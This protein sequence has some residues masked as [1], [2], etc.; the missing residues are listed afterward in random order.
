M[1][2]EEALADWEVALLKGLDEAKVINE[3]KLE[4]VS[5]VSGG[6]GEVFV[7]GEKI[8]GISTV[9]ISPG[10]LVGG[11]A[12]QNNVPVKTYKADWTLSSEGVEVSKP[13][14]TYRKLT[15][16]V[17]KNKT[18]GL[19]IKDATAIGR[20]F[21]YSYKVDDPLATSGELDSLK[22][23]PQKTKD[24][25]INLIGSEV[26]P[27]WHAPVLDMDFPVHVMPSRQPGHNHLYID[28]LV[29]WDDYKELLR[30]MAKMG[31][32]EQGYADSALN[33]GQTFVRL[34]DTDY[35]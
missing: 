14:M 25:P 15:M 5:L 23:D 19:M 9:G 31:L 12:T 7:N 17:L 18:L 16:A 29:S 6:M 4:S 26:V 30:L 20:K 28:K 1:D 21:F 24:S 33:K 22:P 2:N 27:G 10:E 34:P 13:P 35:L 11:F 8:G 32:I 3:A